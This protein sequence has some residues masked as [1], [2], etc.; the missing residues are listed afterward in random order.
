MLNKLNFFVILVCTVCC[1]PGCEKD[2]TV[3]EQ[4]NTVKIGVI[5]P[6]SGY[7]ASSA[8]DLKAGLELSREIV[9]HSFQLPFSLAKEKG[10]PAFGNA[11][12]EF[13]YRD[14]RS[15]PVLA[16]ELV[17]RLVK[18]EKVAAVIGC[19]SSTVTAAAS[20][21]AEILRVPFVNTSSTSPT[22]TQRGLKWFFRTTPDDDM[23]AQNFF[24]FLSDLSEH[25]KIEI[26]KNLILVYENRLWGTSVSRA[27]RKLA[28]RHH[29][30]ILE[31]IPYDAEAKSFNEELKR[32]QKASPGIILQSSYA[33]DAILFM[34]GYKEKQIHPVAL[35]AMNAGFVSPAFIDTLGADA[36]YILS[37]EVWAP[38]IGKKKPLVAEVN[39]L[40]KKR[41]GRNMTGGSA[42]SFTG[43]LV[44]AD[45][46]NRAGN[47]KPEKIRKSLLD[48][49]I[50]SEALIMPWDGVKFDPQTG[51]NLLGKGIIVQ[52]QGGEYRTV[53]P[54]ELS[55]TLV[56]WPM[57][58]RS[59]RG[60]T[61]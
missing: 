10:L 6:F 56:V 15:D 22:L 1:A 53:W 58:S 27:E 5:Y 12:I 49:D 26:P 34:K 61:Q 28:I 36:E 9:N 33:D 37:R 39:D 55:E 25:K 50:K 30:R 32:I 40:F 54:R 23:F 2:K 35:L 48:T 42:R 14:S 41:F 17:E 43:L 52:I 3:S 60:A 8:E 19:Y 21:R 18:A 24:A 46:I 31:D 29:Y 13:C 59:E 20:E 7:N 38:D 44:L 47:L 57:P 11:K 51:Q 4:Q 16:A 45:A